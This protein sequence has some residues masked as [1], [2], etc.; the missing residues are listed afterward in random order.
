MTDSRIIESYLGSLNAYPH[1]TS[2]LFAIGFIGL[3]GSGKSTVATVLAEKLQLP[4][5]RND[6]IRRHLNNLGFEGKSPRQDL[7][8]VLA[9][10]RT[11]WYYQNNTSVIV[12]ADFSEQRKLSEQLADKY[13]AQLLLVRILCSEATCLKRI[14]NR[15]SAGDEKGYSMG[16]VESYYKAVEK[17]KIFPTES[18]FFE[19]TTEQDIEPQ[20][21]ELLKKLRRIK[22]IPEELAP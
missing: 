16:N 21:L 12:D 14:Q 5:S 11:E 10:A 13:S 7:M 18:T 6:Q 8:K 4:L 19:I 20:V 2:E 9:E 1:N 3:P 15:L 17:H 22:L